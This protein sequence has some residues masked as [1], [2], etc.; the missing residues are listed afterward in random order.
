MDTTPKHRYP[1]MENRCPNYF[2]ESEDIV[3]SPTRDNGIVML[4]ADRYNSTSTN[5]DDE[6]APNTTYNSISAS[7]I[8]PIINLTGIEYA[9]LCFYTQLYMCCENPRQ[10]F[11]DISFDNGLSWQVVDSVGPDRTS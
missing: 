5:P 6:S 8:S 10:T 1:D 9:E 2:G 4:D 3:S 7:L 11:V